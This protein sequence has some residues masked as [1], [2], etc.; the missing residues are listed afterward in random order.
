MAPYQPT[1]PAA[2]CTAGPTRYAISSGCAWRRRNG[3]PGTKGE[4]LALAVKH[5]KHLNSADREKDKAADDLLRITCPVT[6]RLYATPC[7]LKCCSCTVD[8]TVV[9]ET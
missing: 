6:Q 8:Q 9:D 7:S 1:T 2:T 5:L 4:V 3:K